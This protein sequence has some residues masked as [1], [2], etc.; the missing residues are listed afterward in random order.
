MSLCNVNLLF[1]THGYVRLSHSEDGTSLTY[2]TS[3]VSPGMTDLCSCWATWCKVSFQCLC[4]TN[5]EIE[6]LT[7]LNQRLLVK[8][9]TSKCRRGGG[10]KKYDVLLISH[11][12]VCV[13]VDYKERYITRQYRKFPLAHIHGKIGHIL[14]PTLQGY[15][16]SY[17]LK[18]I[19]GRK[20]CSNKERRGKCIKRRC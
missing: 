16:G 20:P 1:S 7:L 3:L 14:L 8:S 11:T 15:S 18:N 9:M 2:Q 4:Y 6:K 19:Q 13:C 10:K 5:C 12:S 17:G